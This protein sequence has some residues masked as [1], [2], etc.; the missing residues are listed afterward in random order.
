MG[1]VTAPGEAAR[2]CAFD[3]LVEY[4]HADTFLNSVLT[5]GLCASGLE[6]RDRALIT[7]IVQG[8]VR[9][10]LALD[11]AISGFSNRE[12]SSVDE[13]VLWILRLTAY[14]LL[15]TSVPTYAAC[16]ISVGLTRRRLGAGAS[17][18][19]NGVLRAFARGAD[20]I[21]WPE[22]EDDPVSY[23]EVCTSH[24]RWLV[25]MWIA[26]LG[27]AR[28]ET[29]CEADN[30]QPRL[31]LRC[32]LARSSRE[33]LLAKLIEAGIEAQPGDLAPEALLVRGT[34]YLNDIPEFVSGLFAVQD[35][36]SIVVGHR[37]APEPGMR[38]LDMCAAPGGKANH[39]AELMHNSGRVL[40]IDI[41]P[42]RLEM[43]GESATRLGNSSVETM[44]QDGTTASADLGESFDRV[45]V[46]APCT[47]LGT[48]ARRPDAR[49][50]KSPGDIR[51]LPELQG[52]LL[53]EG[54]RLTTPGGLLV[55][56][57]C[58]ISHRENQEVVNAFIAGGQ[59]ESF[60][61]VSDERDEVFTQ[62]F[63]DADGCD[64]MFVAV[65]RRET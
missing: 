63:P 6:R 62:M 42:G 18:Y 17:G 38:V 22:K 20:D 4:A 35:Q 47:G 31:S 8:T 40:A 37:V 33:E 44:V 57:T 19:V 28:T 53:Q 15:Y 52:A 39:L 25:E 3:I 10:K 54:A 45:L 21:A 50:R 24:P 56:S 13:G 32:N 2:D 59:G 5:K 58:T 51:R 23:L 64:G 60:K 1:R 49:W 16:D 41:N 61:L 9:M 30:R 14:Q 55:Y 43:V 36:G 48:L 65:M 12:L 26:E 11:C 7:E 46:D 34:G 29:L 27:L